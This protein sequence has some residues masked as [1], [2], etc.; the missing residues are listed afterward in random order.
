MSSGAEG[1][2]SAKGGAAEYV[3]P[4]MSGGFGIVAWP[5][6]YDASGIMTFVVNQE[7]VAYEKDLGPETAGA[8]RFPRQTVR[9]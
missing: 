4:E 1:R 9:V 7:G 6:H 8:G 3:D 5:V 2:Q